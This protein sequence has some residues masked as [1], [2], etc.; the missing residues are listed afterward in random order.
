MGQH[1]LRAADREAAMSCLKRALAL[2]ASIL[3][4]RCV[5]SQLPTLLQLV[6]T[7]EELEAVIG[8]VR[9]AKQNISKEKKPPAHCPLSFP[10]SLALSLPAMRSSPILQMLKSKRRGLKLSNSTTTITQLTEISLKKAISHSQSL[11][12]TRWHIPFDP[13]QRLVIRQCSFKTKAIGQH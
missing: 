5:E 10:I 8:L 3:D 4:R 13:L 1:Y 6:K 2:S 9:R 12:K 7:S 11:S